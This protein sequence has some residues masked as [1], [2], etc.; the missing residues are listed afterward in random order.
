MVDSASSGPDAS[1]RSP[2]PPS[3]AHGVSDLVGT[4]L[5]G[6]YRI[7]KKLGDG[8][9]GAVYLGEHLKFGRKDAIKVLHPALATDPEAIARFNRGARNVSAI[10]HRNIC[11]VYDCSDTEE[12][13]QFLA[14]EFIPGETLQDRLVREQ[15]LPLP[16]ALAITKQVADALEAA[17]EAGIAHRDLKPANIM[18]L[19]GRDGSDEVRVVDFDIAKGSMDEDD[20]EVTRVG[21]VVG[22]PEYMSPEQLTAA[23][24][25]GRSDL[26]SLGLILYRM[27]SGTFPF[28]AQTREDLYLGRLTQTPRPIS[29][30]VP[31]ADFPPELQAIL[32]RAL[33]RSVEDRYP[34]A[35][36]FARDLAALLQKVHSPALASPPTRPA[37]PREPAPTGLPETQVQA[38]PTAAPATMPPAVAGVQ[39]GTRGRLLALALVA[40]LVLGGGAVWA[41]S[42]RD[43]EAEPLMEEQRA[44]MPQEPAAVDAAAPE[45]VDVTV[46]PNGASSA[47]SPAVGGSSAPQTI[48]SPE[49]REPIASRPAAPEPAAPA[50]AASSASDVLTT[51]ASEIL[52]RQLGRVATADPNSAVLAATRD[53]AEM[54]WNRDV[55]ARDRARAAYIVAQV[56][57]ARGDSGQCATWARRAV[58]MNP[59]N[60]G[61][62]RLLSTCQGSTT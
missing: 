37:I 20:S 5:A 35:A 12:G 24:L 25:D 46:E 3:E 8:G 19:S 54:I 47:G 21:F 23:P 44:P 7:L 42:S 6:R 4:V 22:T 51:R 43:S 26:Y 1:D 28:R 31:G 2:A 61:Y 56:W 48:S 60:Q 14:M 32:D 27:L 29:E 55:S 39:K 36:T 52:R 62:Q 57:A 34:D 10:R 18:I 58:E 13:F 49:M 41:A 17:H 30:V 15:A 40:V 38:S 53:T 33:Q 16:Q 9:M 59:E 50:P 45:G 11:T